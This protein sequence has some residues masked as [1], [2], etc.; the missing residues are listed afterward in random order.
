MTATQREVFHGIREI[1]GRSKALIEEINPFS[2]PLFKSWFFGK[3][4]STSVD[5]MDMFRTHIAKLENEC[6]STASSYLCALIAVDYESHL[7]G[8][9]YI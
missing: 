5:L 2:F 8:M 4:V 3:T 6:I 7:I 9:I 1:E